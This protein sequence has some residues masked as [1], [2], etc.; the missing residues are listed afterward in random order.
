MRKY[1]QVWCASQM[2]TKRLCTFLLLLHGIIFIN[3]QTICA[4][5]VDDKKFICG[6]KKATRE[7]THL[8]KCRQIRKATLSLYFLPPSKCTQIGCINK[9]KKNTHV[10]PL[11]DGSSEIWTSE[12][13]QIRREIF[14]HKKIKDTLE[15]IIIKRVIE[16][17]VNQFNSFSYL[18]NLEEIYEQ[19][20]KLQ[21]LYNECDNLENLP[22]LF[23]VPVILKDNICTKNIPTTCG[24]KILEKY[25]PSYDSTVV[26]RLKKHGA[27]IVG[28]THLDEFAMGSCTGRG[29]KNPFN[30]NDLSC[31][32]SSGGSASCVGSRI[33]NCSVN[34][35]TGGSIRTPAAL[36][37]CI[38]MKPTYGRISRYGI[39][40]YN[41]ET[42]VVGLIINN[43]YDCSI[44]LDVL[45]GGDKNDLTTL[46]GKEKN[47][48]SKL[49]K[50]EAS[51][52][53]RENK[54]PLKNM[55]FGYLS[56]N[57]LKNYFVDDLTYEGYLKVMQDIEQ[58]G[59]T[60]MN[61]N[62]YELSDYCYLY[63][64]YSMTIANSNLSRINGI[65]YNLH[66]VF[67]KSN[68]VRQV[69]SNLISEQVLTRIIGGS[70]ISSRFQGESLR[71]IFATVKRKLT[72]A[73][74]DIFRQVDFLL[75]PSLPRSNNLKE[76]VGSTPHGGNPNVQRDTVHREKDY[77]ISATTSHSLSGIPSCPEGYNNYMKEIFS[78]VSSITGFPS[79]VIPTGEF[80]AQFNEPQS[81]QLLSRNLNEAGLLNVALAYKTQLQVDKK[82]VENLRGVARRVG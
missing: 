70:I 63:Y 52:N 43:V 35:D 73:L 37:A 46:K 30:E 48:H 9:Y 60:L 36:C 29:V 14:S 47:F 12:V 32:G 72:A 69:R 7:A 54:S 28:K 62:L 31:G 26:R 66:N 38:G 15:R 82:I 6:R 71:H 2:I 79:I 51:V 67:G 20:R 55:K 22:K 24:S 18:Y 76:S 41:E 3:V 80:T 13:Y 81:F 4:I 8:R 45:S 61:T 78:I 21:S 57:L 77:L 10:A 56:E 39:I 40:P 53:F 27:V 42:D 16:G 64:M 17:H 58:M 49:N 65:N 23:G 25:K 50:F 1:Q 44:L 59:G 33:I 68:F 75:L 34:T 19:L 11:R 5:K 74:D